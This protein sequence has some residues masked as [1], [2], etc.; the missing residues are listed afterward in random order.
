MESAL[1]KLYFYISF[2]LL[3]LRVTCVCIFGSNVHVEWENISY[4]LQSV[5]SAAYNIEVNTFGMA[6][7]YNCG[8]IKRKRMK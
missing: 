3:L 5:Q 8:R 4:A 6:K 7:I 2:G 1:E